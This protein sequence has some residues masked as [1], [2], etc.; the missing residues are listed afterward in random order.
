MPHKHLNPKGHLWG[1]FLELRSLGRAK[2]IPG[3]APGSRQ[4]SQTARYSPSEHRFRG[5]RVR[6][7]LPTLRRCSCIP[8]ASYALPT[9]PTIC[10]NGRARR[11]YL[12]VIEL[13]LDRTEA[14]SRHQRT[15]PAARSSGQKSNERTPCHS[16]IY[17]HHTR[18]AAMKSAIAY[19]RPPIK[20]YLRATA[21]RAR[22]W[23]LI[24]NPGR[25]AAPG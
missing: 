2:R 16:A 24:M 19:F 13:I 25:A 20:P 3:L 18:F 9:D 5:S 15:P 21:R 12:V 8:S 14:S 10:H 23:P 1:V 11:E 17:S 4:P 6:S 7:A 22:I